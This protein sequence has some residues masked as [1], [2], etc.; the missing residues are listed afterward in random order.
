MENL[1]K[2]L[3]ADDDRTL[4]PMVQEYLE[5]KGFTCHLHH[6]AFDAYEDFKNGGFSLCILDIKMPMKS[7]F[8][9]AAEIK[10]LEPDAPFLFLTGQTD[11]EDRIKGLEAG[12]DDYITKPFSMQELY[13]RIKAILKRTEKYQVIQSKI[14]EFSIGQFIFNTDTREIKSESGVIKLSSIESKLLRMFCEAHDGVIQ[15]DEALKQIWSD[16]NSFRERSLNVYV[17]KLRNYLKE[18]PSIQFL[19]IHGSGYKLV[20]KQD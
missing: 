10:G 18:D 1:K 8:E 20:V 2:I 19:N 13:L 9:L 7:G 17:S 15:R 4:S 14:S 3:L 11:K 12:A 6:N 5:A 16:E